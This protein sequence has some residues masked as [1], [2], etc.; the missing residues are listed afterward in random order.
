MWGNVRVVLTHRGTW[1]ACWTLCLSQSSLARPRWGRSPQGRTDQRPI[2]MKKEKKE[3]ILGKWGQSAVCVYG[4][5]FDDRSTRFVLLEPPFVKGIL[6]R[7]PTHPLKKEK[8][9]AYF[10]GC[11]VGETGQK[12]CYVS[13]QLYT[14]KEHLFSYMFPPRCNCCCYMNLILFFRASGT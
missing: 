7:H 14:Y 13:L 8:K 4:S 6:W 12:R 11:T 1:A 2:R 3:I 10:L 9:K 5:I